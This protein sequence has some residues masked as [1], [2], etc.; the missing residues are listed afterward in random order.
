MKSGYQAK[1]SEIMI[2]VQMTDKDPVEMTVLDVVSDHLH[3]GTFTA[4]N[5]QFLVIHKH[6]LTGW[7]LR[8]CWH[9]RP[10]T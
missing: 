10:V 9:G 6:Y 4:V 8:G 1:Q 7:V 2:S 3:L 5:H